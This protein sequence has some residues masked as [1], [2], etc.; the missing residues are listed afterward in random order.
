MPRG[1]ASVTINAPIEKVFDVVVD[2]ERGS[3]WASGVSDVINIQG[4]PGE[5]GSSSTLIYHVLGIKTTNT[6][7]VSK[8]E[9]PRTIL[10][11]IS[12][13]FPGT[14]QFTLEPQGQATKVTARLDYSVPGGILGRIASQVLLE[15]MNQKNLESTAEKLKLLCEA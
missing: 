2:P 1:E 5:I 7:T 15:R 8:V 4:N 10:Y 11:E 6:F 13:T 14:F 9:K 3:Q 12:G